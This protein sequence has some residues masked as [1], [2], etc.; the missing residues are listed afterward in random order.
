M[1]REDG[2]KLY[3]L[4]ARARPVAN[5]PKAILFCTSKMER[6]RTFI[7]EQYVFNYKL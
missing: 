6:N 5:R 7:W 1:A 3:R 4:A 2:C